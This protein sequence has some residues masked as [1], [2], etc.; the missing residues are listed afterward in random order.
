MDA[1]DVGVGAGLLVGLV[2]GV[3]VPKTPLLGAGYG[4]DL[5]QGQHGP[6]SSLC[7]PSRRSLPS[8]APSWARSVALLLGT[9]LYS[10]ARN[11]L[12]PTDA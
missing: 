11:L 7:S 3:A 10:S 6:P 8:S 9:D 5:I 4:A 12:Y 2:L 1:V